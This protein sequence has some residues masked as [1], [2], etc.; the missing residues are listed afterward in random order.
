MIFCV[1]Q[2]VLILRTDDPE[3][4]LTIL[5]GLA[6]ILAYPIIYL[7][8]SEDTP[9]ICLH[10]VEQM[11]ISIK[12]CFRLLIASVRAPSPHPLTLSSPSLPPSQTPLPPFDNDIVLLLVGDF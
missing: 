7:I 10:N 9:C 5:I 3:F 12:Q 2:D 4:Y 6:A 11:H 8:V 1:S